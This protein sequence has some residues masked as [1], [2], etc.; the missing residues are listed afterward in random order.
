MKFLVDDC[1]MSRS[2]LSLATWIGLPIRV[3]VVRKLLK[4]IVEVKI[5]ATGDTIE[6]HAD[7]LV[8]R[9]LFWLNKKAS[10]GVHQSAARFIFKD[11]AVITKLCPNVS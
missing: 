4:G 3:T 9:C 2:V 1:V 10:L 6:V 11:S 8:K 7:N 5:R